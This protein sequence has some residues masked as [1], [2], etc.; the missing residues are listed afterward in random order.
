MLIAI[1]SLSIAFIFLAAHTYSMQMTTL[2]LGRLLSS[3]YPK[4]PGAGVQD[5]ITPKAQTIRNLMI[6][7]LAIILFGL[8]TYTYAWYHGLWVVIVCIIVSFIIGPIFSLRPGAQRF[9]VSITSN[10][11][12]RHQTYL[13]AGDT[14]RAQAIIELIEQLEQ[15]SSEEI[16]KETSRL[17]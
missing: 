15:L 16:I 12:R 6:F 1:L 9:V 5:A 10:M 2:A 17:R 11:K 3:K 14:I 8:T 4:D 13:N 7:V